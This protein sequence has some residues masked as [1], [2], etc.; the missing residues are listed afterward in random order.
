MSADLAQGAVRAPDSRKVTEVAVG[1][2]VQ[3]DGSYLLA[4]RCKASRM[5]ATGSFRAASWR[6]V[7][8]SL[9]RELHEARH[10]SHGQP[11]L[12]RSS[13]IIRMRT[14]GCISAR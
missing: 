4:Q 1:V 12:A 2:M 9:A 5:K 8:A 11:P 10:R 7:K 3:P 13:T 6:P 14:C